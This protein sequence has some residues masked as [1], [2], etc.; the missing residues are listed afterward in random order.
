MLVAVCMIGLWLSYLPLA[1]AAPART[2]REGSEYTV[3]WFVGHAAASA[4]P[5]E[6]FLVVAAV[7][8]SL[9]RPRCRCPL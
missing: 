7:A 1:S 2:P 3:R 5:A 4:A 9:F 8:R 6:E